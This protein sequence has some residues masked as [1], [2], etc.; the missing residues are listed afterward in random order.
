MVY[1]SGIKVKY[2]VIE[3]KLTKAQIRAMNK[4]LNMPKTAYDLQE[5]GRVLDTLV[6]LGLAT[7]GGGGLGS[8]FSPDT[9]YT[10]K[11]K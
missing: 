11:L 10:Y 9:T 7:K 8:A 4:L 1:N 2:K 5:Q 6:R 3:M